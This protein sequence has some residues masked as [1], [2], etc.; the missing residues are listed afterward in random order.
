[1]NQIAQR[2]ANHL[3]ANNKFEHSGDH[4]KGKKLGEN[5]AIKWS[6]NGGDITS[7]VVHSL[8]NHSDNRETT[9]WCICQKYVTVS[10]I[11]SIFKRDVFILYTTGVARLAHC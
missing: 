3:A 4:Y 10:V 11:L 6:S 9:E 1:M 8:D 5:L 7:M 2:W